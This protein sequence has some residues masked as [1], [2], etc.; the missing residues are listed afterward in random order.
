[1]I[2][3]WILQGNAKWAWGQSWEQGRHTSLGYLSPKEFEEQQ[4]WKKA[5]NHTGLFF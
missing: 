3:S 2:T 4:V 1:M 5:A